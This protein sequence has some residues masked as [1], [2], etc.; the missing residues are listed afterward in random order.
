M[1]SKQKFRIAVD[2]TV[3]L[4]AA[5]SLVAMFVPVVAD[6]SCY[7]PRRVVTKYYGYV[8][9]SGDG[10]ETPHCNAPVITPLP[11]AYPRTQVGE[12]VT[13]CDGTVTQ[14]G[15]V[16]DDSETTMTV[17]ERVCE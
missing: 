9:D 3:V 2:L 8:Y 14:W 13:E 16:C 15:I 1:A 6:A 10:G 17:C 11:G 7:Y 12:R 5:V 4:V